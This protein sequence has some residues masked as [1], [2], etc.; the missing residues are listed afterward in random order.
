MPQRETM[1]IKKGVSKN[2]NARTCRKF[3]GSSKKK[4][5]AAS[6]EQGRTNFLMQQSAETMSQGARQRRALGFL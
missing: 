5:Q 4:I 3:C 2:Y 6:Q 1:K